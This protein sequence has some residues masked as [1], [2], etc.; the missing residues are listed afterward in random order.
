MSDLSIP[1]CPTCHG[2][3]E[4]TVMGGVDSGGLLAGSESFRRRPHSLS[5][6]AA[7]MACVA[8]F[9]TW[10]LR[11]SAMIRPKASSLMM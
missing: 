11:G 1:P 9:I 7:L 4:T 2:K 3:G 5:P 10:L 6:I 8:M